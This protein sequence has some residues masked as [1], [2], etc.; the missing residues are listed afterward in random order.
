MKKLLILA[1]LLSGCKKKQAEP[2]PEPQPSTTTGTPAPTCSAA[3]PTFVG[4]YITINIP[5]KDTL[6]ITLLSNGC[7][8]NGNLNTYRVENMGI[9]LRQI[10]SDTLKNPYPNTTYTL[11]ADENKDFIQGQ[12]FSI[13]EP[14]GNG[15]MEVSVNVDKKIAGNVIFMRVK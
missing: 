15:A 4:K 2:S 1:I 9:N 11:V 13:F 8:T 10:V 6:R 3:T 12:G 7:P 5:L 14:K